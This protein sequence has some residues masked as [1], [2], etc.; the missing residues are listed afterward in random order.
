MQVSDFVE[1]RSNEIGQVY[2][3]HGEPDFHFQSR[4]IALSDW[5]SDRKEM[6]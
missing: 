3:C 4:M 2:A 6:A 5:L 1:W